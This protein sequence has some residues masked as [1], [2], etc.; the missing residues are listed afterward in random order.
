MTPVDDFEL[1]TVTFG[2]N[3]APFLAIRTLFQLAEDVKVTYPLASQIIRQHLYVDD[4]LAGEHT[5]E[6][7]VRSRKELVTALDSAGFELRKWAYNDSQIIKDLPLDSL[8][9]ANWLD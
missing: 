8:L 1:L 4:V 9:L 5:V 6:Q 2:V 3:C 7:A